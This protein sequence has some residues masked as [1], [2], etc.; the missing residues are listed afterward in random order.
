MRHH[1]YAD[2][3]RRPKPLPASTSSKGQPSNG[4][5]AGTASRWWCPATHLSTQRATPTMPMT[6]KTSLDPE[7]PRDARIR[8]LA[9]RTPHTEMEYPWNL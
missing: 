6:R 4:P 8:A 5:R 1:L 9:H 2:A 7:H 3:E